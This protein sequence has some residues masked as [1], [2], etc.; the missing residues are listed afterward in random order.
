VAFLS[1]ERGR[2]VPDPG[3]LTPPAP[4]GFPPVL[5]PGSSTERLEGRE[6]SPTSAAKKTALASKPPGIA[7]GA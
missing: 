3:D 2:A 7:P 1:L 5:Y 4:T 6:R